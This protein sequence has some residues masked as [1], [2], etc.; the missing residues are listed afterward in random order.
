MS[1][2]HKAFW[3]PGLPHDLHFPDT[4][5]YYNLEV[6]ATRYPD[7]PAVIFYGSILTYGE[8]KRQVDYLAGYLQQHCGVQPG[9][10]V[11]LYSQNCPQFIVG[12]YAIL[13]ACAVVVPT[14]PMNVTSEL[15]HCIDDSGARTALVAQELAGNIQ[16][17]LARGKLDWV[18]VHRYGDYLGEPADMD[19]PAAVTA[20]AEPLAAQGMVN[21]WDA[22]NRVVPPGATLP[23]ADDLAV[24]GYTSGTTG[25][26][27]GCVHS[28]RTV[29]SAVAAAQLWRRGH[30]AATTLAVAPLFHFLGM[31]GG[32]NGPIYNAA[33][34][35]LLQRWDRDAALLLIERHRVSYWSAPPCPKRSR[36]GSR[37]N[38]ACTT[39][40]ALA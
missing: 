14:N 27:K 5:L 2:P 7:K 11:M 4:S 9:D 17:L 28:H 22:L 1:A 20:P 21:W 40:K 36:D 35:A 33:P 26:P 24:L 12:Y 37:M 29:L 34:I 13:R 18:I 19:A 16:P 38:T 15:E 25:R 39:T 30:P 8:L 32:M 31:Q 23:Q 3:P 6:A 10:R